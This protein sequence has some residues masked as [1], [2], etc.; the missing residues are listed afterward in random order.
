MT[1]L[2]IAEKPELARAIAAGISESS[3]TK[4]GYIQCADGT[5]VTWCYGHLFEFVPPEK[6]NPEYAKWNLSSMPMSLMP[7]PIKPTKKAAQQANVIKG[8]LSKASY[9]INAGDPDP[10]GQRLVDEVLEYYKYKGRVG[11][12]L[13]SDLN[14]TA[15]RKAVAEIRPNDEFKPISMSALGRAIFDY[16][17]GMNL[18]RTCSLVAQDLGYDG[19]LSVGRVQTAILGMVV[20]RYR[21][22]KKHIKEP[23]YDVFAVCNFN[24]QEYRFK[25]SPS[26][27]LVSKFPDKFD[28]KNRIKDQALANQLAA[29]VSQQ[30]KGEISSTDHKISKIQPPLPFSLSS[31]QREAN[32]VYGLAIDK[33]L[34][35]TQT[36]REKHHLITYNRT[37]CS[38]LPTD[39]H[40]LAPTLLDTINK[41]VPSLQPV[42]PYTDTNIKCK[43]FNDKKIEAHHAIEPTE[44]SKANL[45]DLSDDERK[46]YELICRKYTALFLPPAENAV[47]KVEMTVGNFLFKASR[48]QEIKKGWKVIFNKEGDVT[49]DEND[50]A[51]SNGESGTGDLTKLQQGQFLDI[52]DAPLKQGFTTPPALYTMDTLLQDM[53]NAAKYITDERLRNIL[54]ERDKDSAQNGGIGT[55]A[56]Q[57]GIIANL[58]SR[59]FI[60]DSKKNV[61][62]TAIGEEFFDALPSF[63]VK[64]DL[65]AYWQEQMDMLAKGTTSITQF[66]DRVEKFV[67]SAVYNVKENGL[68]IKSVNR[69]HYSCPQCQSKLRFMAK[70]KFWS[71][72]NYP[73]CT[74]SFP[75]VAGRPDLNAKPKAKAEETDHDCPKCNKHK[76]GKR[77]SDKGFVWYSCSGYPKCKGSF[78]LEDGELKPLEFKKKTKR[79]ATKKK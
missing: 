6:I 5:L 11:R 32:R 73:T 56:T 66:Q 50:D 48:T 76:L 69:V 46:V 47:S 58:Y 23:F 65:T 9:V 70:H 7:I 42:I 38:Y 13:I 4:N 8:L 62:P 19:V 74:A 41:L 12:V 27:Q 52:N 28:D 18:T 49:E 51:D 78:T 60:K 44:S 79:T 53:N 31:L 55:P 63:A 29:Y 40:R 54:L 10:E 67:N 45:N 17:Y 39:H 57:A 75:D 24:G 33:T 77:K 2:Y 35:I 43:A 16:V 72:S 71:C 34:E 68:N 3:S 36:L 25:L 37:D 22:N 21:A 14:A 59:K 64:V 1:T 61:I 26:E 20:T 30:G 15:V